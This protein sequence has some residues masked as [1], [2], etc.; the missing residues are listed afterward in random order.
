M[1]GKEAQSLNFL[2]GGGEMGALIR[3]RDWSKNAIGEPDA[4]PQSLRTTV[5]I[6]L[7]S[8]FPM[9]V[10]WGEDLITIYNDAYRPIAGE[11]HPALLGKSGKDA[12]AEIWNDLSPL[13]KTVF[14]G[15]STW[16]EDQVLYMNRH[17]Y[18]E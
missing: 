18:T 6:L 3:A 14:S 5:S 4:W 15:T 10:W 11:K 12:W 16:S 17:G 9:F 13:V 8:Q 2:N 1:A 7:N